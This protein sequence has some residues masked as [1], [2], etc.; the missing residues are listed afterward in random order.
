VDFHLL[1]DESWFAFRSFGCFDE[2]PQHGLFVIDSSGILR[3]R[4]VGETPFDNPRE[5]CA[6]IRQLVES[7][8]QARP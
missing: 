3:A 1:I 7:D 6:R 4:Y 5:V 2:H 8:L